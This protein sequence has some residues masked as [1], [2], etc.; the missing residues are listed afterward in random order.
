MTE[1]NLTQ[2][3]RLLDLLEVSPDQGLIRVAGRRAMLMRGDTFE[4]QRAELLAELG[5]DR[6]RSLYARLGYADGT[7]DAA[8]AQQQRP[9]SSY[10]QAF[11]FGPDMHAMSGMAAVE[12]IAIEMDRGSSAFYGEFLTHG[13][14]EAAAHRHVQGLS[15]EP[16]CWMQSG[17]ASGFASAFVGSPILFREIECAAMG[18][19]ACK[20]VGRPLSQWRQLDP[21]AQYFHPQ[22]FV[23]QFDLSAFSGTGDTPQEQQL[24]G[25]SAGFSHIVGRLEKVA[26]TN[27][28]VLLL[29]ET[30]VGKEVFA[31]MLHRLSPRNNGPFIGVNCAALPSDL[32]ESELFGVERGGFTGAVASRAGRFERA[33]AGTLFLDEVGSLSFSAQGKLLRALQEREVERVGGTESIKVDVRVVAATNVDLQQAMNEGRFRRDLYYRLSVFPLRIPPLRERQDDIPLLM[34]FF[35]QKYTQRHQ[36]TVNGFTQQAVIG[37]MQY[38][39]PGNIRE[40]E[41]MV[42]RGV[43][44][45]V[46]ERLIDLQDLLVEGQRLQYPLPVV[47]AEDAGGPH[48]QVALRELLSQVNQHQDGNQKNGDPLPKLRDLE[49][50]L[51]DLAI[52]QANGN[53]AA[54]AR[55]IGLTRR[56]LAYRLAQSQASS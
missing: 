51:V 47:A 17:Y 12:T 36:L 8:L 39:F 23:N 56:Q 14:I 42:E 55:L 48:S 54:A 28:T 22:D 53:Q 9:D 41:N 52:E 25:I 34:E 35:R 15:P 19:S 2:R 31:K 5:I 4:G 13:S 29:G 32:V 10:E 27:A 3:Q 18:H 16:V 49:Q 20:L 11:L 24:V 40:L 37:L 7:R 6:T 43:I 44:L 38:D 46:G 33:Q 45:A 1:P 30:G 21:A 26:P 50:A